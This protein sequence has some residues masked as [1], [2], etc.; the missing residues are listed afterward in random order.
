MTEDGR[1]Q[2]AAEPDLSMSPEEVT[3]FFQEIPRYAVVGSLRRSG[4]PINTAA[5]FHWDGQS[6]FFS[7][8]NT[9]TLVLRLRRDPRVALFVMN[10]SFPIVWVSMEGTVEVVDDPDYKMA[11]GI[12]RRYLD[13]GSESNTMADLDL[14]EYERNY[15]VA[16]RTLYKVTPHAVFSEDTR[17]LSRAEHERGGSGDVSDHRAGLAR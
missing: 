17:K 14:D 7:M 9:R 15:V 6:M 13:P 11:L 4:S 8:R 16:G 10:T 12:M 1:R 3:A 5:G 2:D